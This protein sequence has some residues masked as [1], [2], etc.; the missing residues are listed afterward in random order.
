MTVAQKRLVSLR[1]QN[2]TAL[3]IGADCIDQELHIACDEA[4]PK[5]KKLF[6]S[7]ITVGPRG[8]GNQ[9]RTVS[10]FKAVQALLHM[11]EQAAVALLRQRLQL[12]PI[13]LRAFQTWR[14]PGHGSK[15]IPS[16]IQLVA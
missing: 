11:L 5:R 10:L 2:G 16:V 15:F 12:S 4:I 14:E 6:T 9:L 1:Y 3:A 8:P 13:F 7:G